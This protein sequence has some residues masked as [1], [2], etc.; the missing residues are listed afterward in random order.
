MTISHNLQETPVVLSG[1]L[2]MPSRALREKAL[3]L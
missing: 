2:Q 3:P 1:T